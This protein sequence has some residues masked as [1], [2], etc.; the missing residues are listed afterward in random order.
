M[1]LLP[2]DARRVRRRGAHMSAEDKFD[3]KAQELKGKA[4][5]ALGDATDNK[6]W[7]AEGKKDQTAGSLKQAGEKIKDAFKS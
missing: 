1:V 6:E 5:E 2:E 4:K 7:Q 3:H